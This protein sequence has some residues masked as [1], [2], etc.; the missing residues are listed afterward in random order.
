VN[1]NSPPVASARRPLSMTPAT[2]PATCTPSAP[3][4]PPDGAE[5]SDQAYGDWPPIAAKATDPPGATGD[6]RPEPGQR[7]FTNG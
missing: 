7:R 3:M 5:V 6:G 4:V 2:G 1:L